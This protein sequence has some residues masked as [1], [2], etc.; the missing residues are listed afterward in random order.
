MT[1]NLQSS[2]RM[3]EGIRAA[4]AETIAELLNR[5]RSSLPVIRDF[6][7]SPDSLDQA[8]DKLDSDDDR[9][10][11]FDEILN[12]DTGSEISIAE[13]LN[14]VNREMRLDLL[15]PEMKRAIGFGLSDLRGNPA[16][17]F[18]FDGLC[19]LTRLYVSAEE[20][21]N[22]LCASLMEAK[23]AAERGD[24]EAKARFLRAY[25]ND[26]E[27]QA[28]RTLTRKKATTLITLLYPGAGSQTATTPLS[29]VQALA[30]EYE[31]SAAPPSRQ[32]PR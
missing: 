3:F 1:S 17:I 20:V 24:S 12:L 23:A 14:S 31:R 6:V 18:S 26:V 4:G 21:A 15:S 10:A 5:D 30:R 22:Q 11:S 29:P 13:F 9:L 19:V 2:W 32:N 27:A 28:H 7:G 25:I 8:F 16:E